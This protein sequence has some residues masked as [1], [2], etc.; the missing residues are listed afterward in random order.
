MK[1]LNICEAIQLFCKNIGRYLS[2]LRCRHNISFK[3]NLHTEEVS[4]YG[5]FAL[6]L[7]CPIIYLM[8]N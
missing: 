6:Y 5:F 1:Y 7:K 8:L 3:N 4:L 2:T